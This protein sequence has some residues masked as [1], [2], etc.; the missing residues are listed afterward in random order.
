MKFFD[1]CNIFLNITD[2]M[3]K[4]DHNHDH[5]TKG[6]AEKHDFV[7]HFLMNLRLFK[8]SLFE[9]RFFF[10]RNNYKFFAKFKLKKQQ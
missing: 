5:N 7:F 4:G 8:I 1:F 6:V 10:S 2:E 3:I 9:I